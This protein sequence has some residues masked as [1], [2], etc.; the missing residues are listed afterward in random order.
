MKHLIL[1]NIPFLG[2]A[3]GILFG[4]ALYY[5]GATNR[6][7]ITKMLKLKELTLMKIILFAIGWGMSL[8]YFAVVF[9]IIDLG[10]FSIKTMNL[11]V[12][13]GSFILAI[14]FGFIGLCPGTAIASFGAG[15]LKSIYVII[16]GLVGAYLFTLSYPILKSIGLFENVLGGKTT[17]IFLSD[18][19]NFLFKGT[20][21]I[22][23][24]I[25][26][27]LILISIVIPHSIKE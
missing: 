9:K 15:Y 8:T 4:L 7:I 10:H 13:F 20:P 5:A 2:L 23:V 19:Y 12:V 17:L 1:G 11:G 21:W 16:G 14:G 3:L 25:G 6:V 22:G 24:V 27:T 18:K 26:I